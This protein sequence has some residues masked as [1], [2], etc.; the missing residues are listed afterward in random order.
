MNVKNNKTLLKIISAVIA[1]VLWFAITYTED[2]VISQSIVGLDLTVI[3]ENTLNSN[4]FAIVNRDSFPSINVVIR[5]S[6]SNVISALGEISAEIDVSSIKQAGENTVS[7]AYSYPSGKVIL[8]KIKVRE[9]TVETESVVSRDIPV[10]IE[11]VNHDKNSGLLIN[12]VCKTET[13]T[14]TG[15]ESDLYKIAYAKA[16]VDVSKITKTSEQNCVYDFFSED[17]ELLSDK[18]ITNKSTET[19]LVENKVYDKVTLP[20]KVVLDSEKRKN[21]GFSVKNISSETV[22]V[23]FDAGVSADYIEAVISAQQGKNGYEATLIVPNG[24]YIPEENKVIT[25]NGEIVPKETKQI[26]VK[27][28]PI[29]LPTGVSAEII[30][31][32]QTISV[33]T[34]ETKPEITAT[35]DLSDITGEEQVLPVEFKTDGDADII[36]KYSVMVKLVQG[37]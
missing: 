7:V 16:V 2:P 26:T 35:V 12:S 31:N 8:E 9:I 18:N 15:A 23:G 28:E 4:G 1:I 32:E 13:V 33:R 11:T 30:P 14:I 36:G 17:G 20:I 6:R 25:V 24:V 22:D 21:Y 37:E 10:K 19:V 5:G 27:V 29:N 34:A 3:G